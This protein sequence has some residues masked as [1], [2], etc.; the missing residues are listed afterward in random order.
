MS[1]FPLPAFDHYWEMWNERDPALV[2]GHLD[3][4]VT[5]DF[6]FCD[7]LEFYVGRDGLE[8]NV[9]E[10]RAKQP[11][12]VFVLASGV[13]SHHNRYRYRWDFTRRGRTL[14]KGFDVATVAEN[15]LIERV[16]GFFGDLPPL[17]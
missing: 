16:N 7:P 10:F 9:H 8:N 3:Q 13:D 6:I 11:D 17:A 4:A 14:V 12:A 2:R 5:T 1:Q 15:G